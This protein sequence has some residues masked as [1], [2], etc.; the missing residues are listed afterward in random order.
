MND[1]A[2]KSKSA[3]RSHE[4]SR[5][6]KIM[7]GIV[8]P[9]FGL[10]AVCFIVFGV[11]N[12]TIWKPST[13]ISASAQAKNEQYI[14][15][16][17][18]M[19][20]AV[21]KD[22]TVSIKASNPQTQLCMAVATQKDATGWVEG[23]PYARISGLE[24]WTQLEV[25]DQKAHGQATPSDQ[26]VAFADSDMWRQVKCSTGKVTVKLK[27]MQNTPLVGLIDMGT[28]QNSADIVMEW[29]RQQVPDFAMP[30]YFAAGL[31][32]VL[33]VLSASVFAMDPEKRRKALGIDGLDEDASTI[34]KI[35][36][37]VKGKPDEVTVGEAVAGTFKTMT[38]G[39]K[40]KPHDPTKAHR[41][42]AKPEHE[43]ESAPTIIDPTNRNM[44][45]KTANASNDAEPAT[46]AAEEAPEADETDVRSA[47]SESAVEPQ[48][49]PDDGTQTSVITQDELQAYFAR[50]ARE[51]HVQFPQEP[52]ADEQAESQDEESSE[53]NEAD[54]S[55]SEEKDEQ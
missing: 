28:N 23:Y 30:F 29:D 9:I 36:Q 52:A 7:R 50:L 35:H 42:H 14:M 19:L 43:E 45:V 41:R 1:A 11:L 17:Q 10:L 49:A 31:C 54:D 2:E 18:G 33:A 21:D 8:T 46:D 38:R 39:L 12:A 3:P 16:D 47:Q 27:D 40:R 13:H 6:A 51:E 32:I 55:A 15:I 25:T 20:G 26:D 53:D 4:P 44:L 5:H 37:A 22:V 24:S 34:A 48:A